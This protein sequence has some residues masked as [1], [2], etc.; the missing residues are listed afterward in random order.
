MTPLGIE[1]GY[2]A[3]EVEGMGAPEPAQSTVRYAPGA[4]YPTRLSEIME[5]MATTEGHRALGND[6]LA[7]DPEPRTHQALPSACA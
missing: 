4:A 2:V 6:A 7:I 3:G 1:G 5:L